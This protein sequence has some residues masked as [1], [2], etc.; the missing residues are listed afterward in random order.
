[1]Y[2]T[3][4]N[5]R[6]N[7]LIAS[8]Y[9]R[10]FLCWFWLLALPLIG[11]GQIIPKFPTAQ[12]FNHMAQ[13]A[14][15]TQAAEDALIYAGQSLRLTEGTEAYELQS[16]SYLVQAQAHQ[17]L[18]QTDGS[19]KAYLNAIN[20]LEKAGDQEALA[21]VHTEVGLMYE[22]MGLPRKAIY[23]FSHSASLREDMDDL[24]GQMI[25]FEQ[26]ARLHF[27]LDSVHQAL[28]HY[29]QLLEFYRSEN[30]EASVIRS[31]RSIVQC[32][33]GQEEYYKALGHNMEILQ[34]AYA[35]K[36][37][38]EIGQALNDIGKNF[39]YLE[40]Y[41]QAL[42]HFEQAFY[43]SRRIK[44]EIQLQ[45]RRHMDIG[46]THVKMGEEDQGVQELNEC[47]RLLTNVQDPKLTS[48]IHQHLARIHLES[49]NFEEADLHALSAITLAKTGG[50]TEILQNSYDIYARILEEEGRFKLALNYYQAHLRIRDSLSL[51][52]Q[53]VR[54][55]ANSQ[56]QALERMERD[57]Q[58]EMADAERKNLEFRQYQ[59]EQEKQAQKVELLERDKALQDLALKQEATEKQQALNNLQLARKQIEA[60]QRNKE[61][62]QL[63][64]NKLIQELEL[65]RRALE[66]DKQNQAIQILE[67][68]SRRQQL[69]LDAQ[70]RQQRYLWLILA[71]AGA[72]LLLLLI[73]FFL[74]RRSRLR[75]ARQNREIEQSKQKLENKNDELEKTLNELTQAHNRLSTAQAQLVESEKMASLGLLTAGIAHEINNPINFVS[76]NIS[77]LKKDFEELRGLLDL[78]QIPE[79]GTDPR[80]KLLQIRAYAEEIEAPYLFEE[81][82]S[83]LLGIEEGAI[84]TKEI[85]VGLKNFSRL[86]EDDFKEIDI[87]QGL[88]ST[89]TLL[90]NR[91]KRHIRVEKHYGALPL[92]SCLPGKINQVFMNILTNAIQ[93]VEAKN[94]GNTDTSQNGE[95]ESGLLGLIRVST[96]R[97]GEDQVRISIEDNGGGISKALRQRIFEPFFTTKD[98]GKGTGLGLS[99]TYGIVERHH[100]TIEV[101]S[102]LGK[103]TTFM[104]TLPIKQSGELLKSH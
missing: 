51:N 88:D 100:G 8:Q 43:M 92:V 101:E 39:F 86:D 49:R 77:P 9:I 46:L 64:Q 90:N 81:I 47:L 82:D 42:S 10:F 27:R 40:K 59:L 14:L 4:S 24:R 41:S 35:A 71:L 99:I 29:S 102:E 54:M 57:I 93:A 85:V 48:L 7:P 55:K 74:N 22:R 18:E 26:L 31:L 21:I 11:L 73:V 67:N 60:E 17:L 63:Q 95:T 72:I 87:H 16:E 37:S 78:L 94:Y 3:Q 104:I 68:D 45:V 83:L 97:L 36:D 44:E 98:V 70:R 62:Q 13:Q 91:I 56:R 34:S 23:Y 89:L 20:A 84:R 96:Q 28:I 53:V 6:V 50:V 52:R 69:L 103:G 38:V 1:M 76:S 33:L 65:E 75:L 2:V 30:N 61:I 80:E 58:L 5:H 79:N 66:A 32:Y 19:L 12:N 25:N 15:K